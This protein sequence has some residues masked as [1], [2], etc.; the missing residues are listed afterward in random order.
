M[1]QDA[2]AKRLHYHTAI[3]LVTAEAIR[4]GSIDP[5]YGATRITEE[6]LAICRLMGITPVVI[7]SGDE[8]P[9]FTSPEG[10]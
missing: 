6:S 5:G 3:V 9:G 2:K 1:A 7:T 4:T 8:K 10:E